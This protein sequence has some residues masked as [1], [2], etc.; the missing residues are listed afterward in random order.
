MTKRFNIS[1]SSVSVS[2]TL[3]VLETRLEAV[4]TF[5][6]MESMMRAELDYR[7]D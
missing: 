4:V 3:M 6:K 5:W 2:I 7:S 1:K